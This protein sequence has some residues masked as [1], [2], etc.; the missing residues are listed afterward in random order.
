MS[1]VTDDGAAGDASV[2]PVS[3]GDGEPVSTGDGEE[4]YG[5][6]LTAYPYAFRTSDSWTFKT[7]TAISGLL[8]AVVVV[9]FAFALV[10][11]LGSTGGAPG[12]TFTFSRAFFVF[13]MLLVLAPLVAPVLLV[14]R[15]HR[16]T[17][18]DARYDRALAVGG[19]GYLLALYLS[20]VITTPPDL[21]EHPGGV[22]GAL[23]SFLYGLPRAAA[24]LP[25]VLAVALIYLA[26]RRSA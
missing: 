14:A 3:T 5:G 19:Y 20:L 12:G 4:S 9:L 10:T 26:H 13:L 22:V 17:G 2:A 24:V 7:Y 15:R 1:D 11:L 21:Q 23:A 6:I 8:A 16:R 25:P 18:S